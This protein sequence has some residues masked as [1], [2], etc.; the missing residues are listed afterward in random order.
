[1]K[2]E[3][4]NL[5][6]ASFDDTDDFVRL[7]FDR[8]Y[9]DE[10]T[11]TL[12]EN[13]Q[14]VS[15]LQMIP[16]RMT[17]GGTTVPL[18]YVCGVCTRPSE[19]GRGLM[20]QLMQQAIAEMRRRGF[21]LTALIPASERLAGYYRRFGYTDAFYRST[22]V[23]H[24]HAMPSGEAFCRIVSHRELPSET[25]FDYFDRKCRERPCAVLHDAFGWETICMDCLL[26]GGDVWL[27]LRDGEAVGLTLALPQPDHSVLIKEILYEHPAVKTALIRFAM[28]RFH[29]QTAYVRTPSAPAADAHPC[30]MAMILDE[31]RMTSLF[32]SACPGRAIPNGTDLL[33]QTLPDTQRPWMNLMLD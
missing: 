21:T 20:H 16:Y 6:K 9:K 15:A 23:Y 11:L 28:N 5:W 33:T 22:E 7:Y 12:R 30:G 1:M 10:Y 25:V 29:C 26:D 4:L 3:I 31:E 14:V 19:R 17:V 2:A 32:Q 13:G 24:A 18:A 27:A 8:V